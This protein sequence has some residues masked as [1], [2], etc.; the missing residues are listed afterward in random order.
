MIGAA[1][2]TR[3]PPPETPREEFGL[4][5]IGGRGGEEGQHALLHSFPAISWQE[6][7][8][9]PIPQRPSCAPTVAGYA[10]AKQ[11][12]A[13]HRV[14]P[15][16]G[17]PVCVTRAVPVPSLTSPTFTKPSRTSQ[18][19]SLTCLIRQSNPISLSYTRACSAPRFHFSS[20]RS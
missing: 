12:P 2:W 8:L 18:M 3:S 6:E 5:Q 20:C 1:A 10:E 9:Q 15:A 16:K 4:T 14:P 19:V 13:L 7:P 11:R 17:S